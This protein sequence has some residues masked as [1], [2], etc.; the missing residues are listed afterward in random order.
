MQAELKDFFSFFRR[1][2]KKNLLR[3]AIRN[4]TV[5]TFRFINFFL[6]LSFLSS[7]F[8]VSS[9]IDCT[10][11]CQ[12]IKIQLV[13]GII[14]SSKN[15]V[16]LL[17]QFSARCIYAKIVLILHN[18]LFVDPFIL[19]CCV[20][21]NQKSKFVIKCSK[22]YKNSSNSDCKKNCKKKFC[23]NVFLINSFASSIRFLN[24]S[25]FV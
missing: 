13:D 17:Y 5:Q 20:I 1:D 2:E 18:A 21:E 9:G 10:D 12:E 25:N 11:L 8:L 6:F 7:F 24:L 3:N 16:C 19:F 14:D 4:K 23:K 15:L 22:S